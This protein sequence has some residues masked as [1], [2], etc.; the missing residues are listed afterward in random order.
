M[1]VDDSQVDRYVAELMLI[2]AQLTDKIVLYEDA[3]SA[4][5]YIKKISNSIADLPELILLDINMP[6]QNG[7]DFL[8]EFDMLPEH[9]KD[10][11]FI[12]MLTS[13]ISDGDRRI[14][15]SYPYVR[16]I[17]HK[18]LTLAELRNINKFF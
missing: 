14:V 18:P 3:A 13:S 2:K 4:L 10:F 1:V 15:A 16:G 17:I 5:T 6:N 8:N 7:F 12:V 9:I 11:V